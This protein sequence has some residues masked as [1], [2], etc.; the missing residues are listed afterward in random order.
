MSTVNNGHKDLH[1]PAITSPVSRHLVV[2]DIDNSVAFYR[3][4]L[5]FDKAPETSKSSVPSLAEVVYGPARIQF[6]T[7]EGLVVDSSGPLPPRGSAMVFFEVE[8]VQGMHAA[9]AARGGNPSRPEKVN[10]IKIELFEVRDPDGHALWFGKSY[11]EFYAHLHTEAGA[12]QLRKIMPSMPLNDVPAGIAWYRDVLGFSINYAQHDLGVMDR[13]SV[14][15]LLVLRTPQHTGIASCYTYI[16]DAD[17][18]YAEL[19]TKG[20]AIPA[21]PVSQPWGLRE[22]HVTD[23]E[24]NILTFGQ[25]FE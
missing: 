6:Y 13:D 22:F 17:A 23:P 24:G 1:K 10:W 15:L 14:R 21:P 3:D 2:R 4:V 7:E 8:D 20:A 16:R 19:L 25:T 12:G 5:G 9:I 11:H 18:L